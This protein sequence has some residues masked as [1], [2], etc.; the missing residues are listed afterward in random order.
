MVFSSVDKSTS[1][2]VHGHPLFALKSQAMDVNGHWITKWQNG[3]GGNYYYFD[4]SYGSP[5]MSNAN[6][7]DLIKAYENA[8]LVGFYGPNYSVDGTDYI[9][10]RVN[11]TATKEVS[12]FPAD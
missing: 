12:E 9:S 5:M 10:Q 3:T 1:P 8:A 4:P 2:R 6:L 11:D 7:D